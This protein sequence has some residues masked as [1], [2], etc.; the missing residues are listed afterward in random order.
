VLI[1]AMFPSKSIP[2]PAQGVNS[3]LESKTI[4]GV[5]ELN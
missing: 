2:E 1:L 5:Q 3:S 4:V